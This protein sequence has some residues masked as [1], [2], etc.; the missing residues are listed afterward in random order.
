LIAELQ[1]RVARQAAGDQS[2]FDPQGRIDP[3]LR[4]LGTP[5][6][7]LLSAPT[8]AQGLFNYNARVFHQNGISDW[9]LVAQPGTA[10]ITLYAF[11]ISSYVPPPVASTIPPDKQIFGGPNSVTKKLP[12]L[13]GGPPQQGEISAGGPSQQGSLGPRPQGSQG[14]PQQ[15]SIV[16][17]P[18]IP[19]PPP[20]TVEW[21]KMTRE[22]AGGTQKTI[23]KKASTP[24]SDAIKALQP[25]LFATNRKI[26][27]GPELKLASITA[28][29]SSQMRYGLAIVSVPKVHVIGNVERPKSRF[30]WW[31]TDKETD[32][33]HFRVKRLTSFSRNEFI[34]ALKEDN[35]S[36]LL[37]VHGYHVTFDDAVFRA[38]QIA[39]D[40]NYAG[41]VVVFSWPSAGAL[42]G[43]DYD[44]ESALFSA[45]DLLDVLKIMTQEIKKKRI[46]VVAHSL[47]NQIVVDALQQAALSKVALNISELVMAAP[48]VDIDV[49]MKKA[50]DIK[51]VA[52]KITMYASSKDKA[53]LASD[54]KAWG[55]RMGYIGGTGPNLVEGVETIDVT[56]VGEDM[57]GLN[58]STFA[59][60]RSV[61]DD[62]GRLIISGVHPPGLRSPTL[63]FMP[64]K[65]NTKYW[66]YP[67]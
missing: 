36:I 50:A 67:Q 48:D 54:K 7:I 43:Y 9:T 26:E 38:A 37:F 34:D 15:G 41:S 40:A 49:F 51:K 20:G 24:A 39:Y 33:H 61:L 4:A 59:T 60:N 17:R 1:T 31:W 56:A 6:T 27:D 64:D 52:G 11:T 25:I 19:S 47:G 45:G 35:N 65:V 10:Q 3:Q 21:S 57:F 16:S 29:R 53:L 12:G 8:P 62:L 58:H 28:S 23:E 5:V 22:T 46:Y 13:T 2:A 66:M 18:Q 63:R 14:P 55:K 42:F 44:R 30:L 32:E